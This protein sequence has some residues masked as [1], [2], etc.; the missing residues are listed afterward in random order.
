MQLFFIAKMLLQI[1][2]IP[3]THS[4]FPAVNFVPENTISG[5]GSNIIY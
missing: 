1:R 5:F 4:P 3:T 2:Q